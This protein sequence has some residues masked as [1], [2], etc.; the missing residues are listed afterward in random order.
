[1]QIKKGKEEIIYLLNRAIE[2]YE[3]ETGMPVVQN[4]NRKNYEGL[5]KRLSEI[6]NQ[7]PETATQFGHIP[8]ESDKQK[9]Q[10]E[11]PFRKYDITGGQIKD[12][13]MGLVANPRPFL[14]DTCYIYVYGV[15][16]QSFEKNPTDP[17]LMAESD[18]TDA[19]PAPSYSLLQEN[20]QLKRTIA[21]LKSQPIDSS[22]QKNRYRM[23]WV[24]LSL[25]LALLAAT[26]WYQRHQT[27]L[28][29]ES[30][31]QAFN[32]LPYSP[33]QAE[34]DSLEG[35]WMCYIGSPQARLSD[36]NR[37]HKVVTNLIEIKF[38][39]GYF[40]YNRYGASFNHTGYIQ[41]EAPG[42]ASIHSRVINKQGAVESPRHS[43]LKL[44]K[45]KPFLNAISASW[46][47]D[48]GEQNRI[49]GIRELYQKL[50]KGGEV[51]EVIN[52]VENASCQCKII[53]WKK[54][55]RETQTFFLKNISLDSLKN[56]SMRALINEN[57]I[58]LKDIADT[59]ILQH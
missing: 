38:Q 18:Q 33:T 8:Y 52:S 39:D 46:S 9:N 13:L 31:K 11:Y 19:A 4:T 29:W 54:N 41:M 56:E 34:I 1:L 44:E 43:L 14:V 20:Q 5:A 25:G 16:R 10:G 45:N 40:S 50:G 42:I 58:L 22:H 30:A 24:L 21:Q 26:G 55:N 27:K 17:L 3:T 51:E 23:G 47:F 57:S 49:I 35:I 7:L 53:R 37:Y 59:I 48:V 12:A 28:Q 6:S 2:R 36:P 32:L 15:G